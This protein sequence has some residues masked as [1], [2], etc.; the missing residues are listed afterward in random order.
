MGGATD[1][2]GEGRAR[3]EEFRLSPP[4]PPSW[5]GPVA[6]ALGSGSFSVELKK[7]LGSEEGRAEGAGARRGRGGYTARSVPAVSRARAAA[8]RRAA[9][10]LEQGGCGERRT[11]TGDVFKPGLGGV[12][13]GCS[14]DEDNDSDG[15]AEALV[16]GVN[17]PVPT[18]PQVRE[19]EGG[20]ATGEEE[21]GARFRALSPAPGRRP[22][23]FCCA[24]V[25][26]FQSKVGDVPCPPG[27]TGQAWPTTPLADSD[28]T[29]VVGAGPPRPPPLHESRGAAAQFGAASGAG[30][31]R[32]TAGPGAAAAA[33]GTGCRRLPEYGGAGGERVL[34]SVCCP[35][36]R[37]RHAAAGLAGRGALG[38][39]WGLA[40]RR[41]APVESLGS[42]AAAGHRWS[43]ARGR[44]L[45]GSGSVVRWLKGSGEI[46][47]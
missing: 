40:Q 24:P 15:N 10:S 12:R 28:R 38:R 33:L 46:E 17:P 42:G 20:V 14:C 19:C 41:R 23:Q 45:G 1:G 26:P 22:P 6:R 43:P 37:R 18:V 29:L 8:N 9:L 47:A 34:A 7:Q 35:R 2:W 44:N 32:H 5:Y 36:G 13:G 21:G 11:E 25:S 16:Q 3:R 31:G 27:P 4:P 39:G 30:A